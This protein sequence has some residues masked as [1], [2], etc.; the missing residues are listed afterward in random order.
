MT[1]PENL[2]P[3]PG[4]A[5]AGYVLPRQLTA[6]TSTP[7]PRFSDN[8]WDFRAFVPRTAQTTRLDF[9]TLADGIARRTAKEYLYS[10]IRR[11]TYTGQ[12]TSKAKPMKIT[13]A[14][15]EFNQLRVILDTFRQMGVPRLAGVTRQHLDAALAQWKDVSLK[16][17]EHYVATLKHLAAHGAFLT[18]DRLTVTPWLGRSAKTVAGLPYEGENSTARIPEDIL[19]PLLKAA[20]FYVETASRDILAARSEIRHLRAALPVAVLGPGRAE[21]GLQAFIAA[22]RAQGR[23]IPALPRWSVPR[24][25]TPV[26]DG[27]A[28]APNT[29][30]AFLLAGLPKEQHLTQ[31]L[32]AA[33]AEL[34][35]E[36]GGLDTP[37]ALWPGSARPWRPRFDPF[38]IREEI[39]HLRAA[40]WI[41]IAYLSGMRDIEVR[42]LRRDCA[43]T[44]PGEDS[45]TRYKLRGRVYK[46][47]KLSGDEAEWVVLEIVHQAAAV[48]LELNDDPTHLFGFSRGTLGYALLSAVHARIDNFRDHVNELFSTPESPFIPADI[49]TQPG[50]I[51]DGDGGDDTSGMAPAPWHFSPSQFRRTLAWHIAH[52]P[53]GVVAGARQYQ[54]AKIAIFE[55]YAGTSASGFGAEVAAEEAVAKLDYLEDLYRD[56]NEGHPSGGGA[57]RRI[58]AEFS[59][60]RR[61]LGDLPGVIASPA[62]LRTM[63]AHLGKVLYP[64]TLNDCFHQPA[65]A[66]CQKRAKSLGRPLPMLDMCTVCPNARRSTVHLPRLITAR[67]QAR[68]QLISLTA[69]GS[70][71]RPLTPLQHAALTGHI[72]RFD[73]LIAELRP[74]GDA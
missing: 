28:Q 63:L 7:G 68:Q 51:P 42:E 64:G 18:E 4:M 58:D 46:G 19:G 59:R 67:D 5:P 57:A 39:T 73:R 53:F 47:R 14:Y 24:P 70:S 32:H 12:G 8:V 49:A 27:V 37:I 34:G 65:T 54:H 10:R 29:A 56:W 35:Y 60:I 33:G 21:A 43:F 38:A 11:G 23:G 44:E 25:G 66:V 55:G 1:S 74:G 62:R 15:T 17:A 45:R 16:S 9:T 6:G 71:A 2:Q 41:I 20:V 13:H 61:E 52:Q 36:D 50:S 26:I 3:D 69:T 72:D 48:L 31:M 30:L 22:R 40:C